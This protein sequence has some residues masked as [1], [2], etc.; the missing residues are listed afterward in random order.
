MSQE[1]ERKKLT[2]LCPLKG[3]IDIISRKWA[4][5]TITAI[6][7][8]GSVRYNG[9]LKELK[10]ISPKTLADTLKALQGAGLIRRRSFGEIP[11]RVEYSL[12]EDGT[13]LREAVLPLLKWAA[14]RAPEKQCPML[15][16]H[17]ELP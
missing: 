12:T 3:V 7:N 4:L 2:Y 11:P 14:S 13:K 6:G 1:S 16:I 9:L 15:K 8:H 5:L 10:G 17:A